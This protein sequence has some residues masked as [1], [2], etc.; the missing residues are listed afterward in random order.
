MVTHLLQNFLES[1]E[2]YKKSIDFWKTI[3]FTLLSVENLTFSNYLTTTNK[4]GLLYMDGN[5]VFN[6]RLD[7]S[8]RAVRIIQEKIET[9]DVE[10][11]AWID[12]LELEKETV[13]ELVISLELSH[14]SALLAIEL[15]NSWIVNQISKQKM[16]T[17]ID[18]LILLKD[19]IF[20]AG[21]VEH[22]RKEIA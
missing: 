2:E 20:L 17:Y 12:T 19:T 8:N 7:H 21:N 6:F 1:E 5:P 9:D 13:E 16:E 3:V 4:D 11:S 15:I 22:V 10:F 14:E 18:K